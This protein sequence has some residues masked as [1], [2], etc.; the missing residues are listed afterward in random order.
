MKANVVE[1]SAFFG[2]WA[3]PEKSAAARLAGISRSKP[4]S[5]RPEADLLEH[6]GGDHGPAPFWT[7]FIENPRR[8]SA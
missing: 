7:W 8:G 3:T 2:G 1:F 5:D 4:D 6:A